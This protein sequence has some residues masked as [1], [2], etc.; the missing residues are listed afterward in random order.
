MMK[1]GVVI[2]N[3]NNLGDL[4]EC[5]GSVL[6]ADDS[7]SECNVVVVD[8]ASSDGSFEAI[9]KEFLQIK[10]L[11]TTRNLGFGGG[12]NLGARTLLD[13]GADVVVMLN[14]DTIV[15]KDFRLSIAKVAERHPGPLAICPKIRKFDN[16]NLIESCGFRVSM[17]R[18]APMPRSYGELDD[19]RFDKEEEAFGISGPAIIVNRE[20]IN[21]VGLLD[22][23]Y[24]LY[25]EDT[26]YSLRIIK[27]GVR[28]IF[29]PS[30][31]LFHK[32]RRSDKSKHVEYFASPLANFFCIRNSLALLAAHGSLYQ[33]I[34]HAYFLLLISLPWRILLTALSHRMVVRPILWGFISRINP[35]RFPSDDLMVER[36][37]NS[38]HSS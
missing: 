2:T 6:R 7:T 35:S 8:N 5:I 11:H 17:I 24:F 25:E 36:L 27:S 4:R 29:A 33:K 15:R 34:G 10:V 30:V 19:G 12:N 3:Y 13:S 9:G 18:G 23:S 16:P 14:N 32:G 37:V 38:G 28:T 31:V 1:L 26:D 22:P 20:L 21:K